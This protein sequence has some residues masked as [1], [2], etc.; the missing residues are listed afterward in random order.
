MKSHK[1]VLNTNLVAER[2]ASLSRRL[3]LRGLGA[4]M[5]LPALESL[6][7]FLGGPAKAAATTT[8]PVRMAF[9]QVPNGII[10]STWLPAGQGGTEFALSPTLQP[11]KKVRHEMQVI[12]GLDDLSANAGPDGG[13]DHARAG[14]TFLTG[15]RI[16]K[17]SGADIY[18]G[19]S[20]DQVVADKIGHLTRFRSLE[21]SCEPNNRK[22]GDCDSGYSC[23]YEYNISWRSPTQPLAPEVN[24]RLVFE[25]LF[26]AGSPGQ[27]VENLK[28]RQMDE[29]SI[30]DFVME[31]ARTI[32]AKMNGRDR[33]KLDQYLTSVREIEQRIE[34]AERMP[35]PNLDTDAPPGLPTDA[36]EHMQLMFDMLFLAF[37]TDSTRIATVLIAKEGSDR[38]FPDI[39]VTGGH[40]TIS[41]HRN[42]P[43]TIAQIA[44]IDLWYTTQLAKFLEKMEATKDVDGNSLLHN[45]M[46]LYGSGN[47][48]G[49]RHTHYDLPITVVGSGGGG[50]KTGRYVKV[51]AKPLTNLFLTMA[52]H[53]GAQ[54]I[55]R[56]GDSTGRLTV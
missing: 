48:D 35:I 24:P 37:Q 14:A 17:T 18:A 25:R 36:G 32:T 40:H 12:S 31:D 19:T 7:P 5:A 51:D 11:L 45:S 3:F 55:E 28:R 2:Q 53:M 41:H 13:G 47:G 42:N 8:A 30:L 16:K 50:F 56:L 4:C 29:R 6:N 43:E 52:D 1:P 39:G 26:G 23:A 10:P 38:I 46:I 33:Q 34:R 22:S 21:L 20:I 44:K 27:R 15:V 9:L 49:N 54:G